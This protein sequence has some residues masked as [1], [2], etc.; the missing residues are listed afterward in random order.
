M[1]YGNRINLL[2]LEIYEKIAA[3]EVIERPLSIVKELVE[4]SIDADSDEIVVEIKDGG[5]TYIRVTDKGTGIAKE[6]VDKAFMRHATSKVGNLSDLDA[7]ETLGFRGEALTSIAAV[8]K[9]EM[10]TKIRQEKIGTRIAVEGGRVMEIAPV[11]CPDGTTIIVRDVFYNMPA[12][13][14]FMK[15]DTREGAYIIDFLSKM[16]LAYPRVSFRIIN[17]GSVSFA[18]RGNGSIYDNIMTVYG[19]DAGEHLIEVRENEE[20]LKLLA[21]ISPPDFTRT[22]RKGQIFFVNGRSV[23]DKLIESSISAAYKERL[24][25]RR[26]PIAFVFLQV[27]EDKV[28]VNIH[29]NKMEVRFF[30]SDRVA[31]FLVNALGK[32]LAGKDSIPKMFMK[33]STHGE[34]SKDDTR[35][36]EQVDIKTLL[37]TRRAAEDGLAVS[38]SE[39]EAIYKENIVEE[40]EANKISF[41]N[42]KILGSI[43]AS[44]ILALDDKQFLLIDQHAAHER[45]LYE[46]LIRQFQNTQ[47]DSQLLISSI[48]FDTSPAAANNSGLWL[49]KLK[50]M[51]FLI[52]PFGS[53]T[54]I[55]KGIPTFMDM[56]EAKRFIFN[57]CEDAGAD[58]KEINFER[59]EK[60]ITKSCKDAVKANNILNED[61]IRFLLKELDMAN[62]PYSCPHGRPT[63]LILSKHDVEKMFKRI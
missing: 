19:G 39:G 5:R 41:G 46:K 15:S 38:I 17:N 2:P 43:F 6:E 51:G 32:A 26:F 63:V 44:Y 33:E 23:N 53:R 18:T 42:L 45:V 55:V 58:T 47:K 59:L 50:S 10:V 21:Y 16:A 52:E 48:V 30:D 25:G 12:R 7:I 4:N 13:L 11:G 8:S 61:E 31:K 27:A 14:K 54:F 3:G 49:P 36:D 20:D 24:Q 35:K 40:D 62:M 57:F 22:N 34:S 29:P 60:I 9:V 37:S 28:D 56:E 1:Q